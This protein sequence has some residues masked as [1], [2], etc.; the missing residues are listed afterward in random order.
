MLEDGTVGFLDIAALRHGFDL[1]TNLGGTHAIQVRGEGVFQ[2]HVC[3][4]V[5]CVVCVACI[6]V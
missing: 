5:W 2:T 1:M 6:S 4:C 3:A